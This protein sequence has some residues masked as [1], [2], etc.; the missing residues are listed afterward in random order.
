MFTEYLLC[1]R[2]HI[3]ALYQIILYT[4]CEEGAIILSIF[5]MRKLRHRDA[6]ASYVNTVSTGVGWD[7]NPSDLMPEPVLAVAI[8]LKIKVLVDAEEAVN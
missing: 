3:R 5:Q 8:A 7:L 4:P 1:A 2:H 6:R